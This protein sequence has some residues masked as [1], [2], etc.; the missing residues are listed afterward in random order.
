ML[1]S[2]F[3]RIVTSHTNP[4]GTRVSH[5]RNV[6]PSQILE[7]FPLWVCQEPF[8]K[9]E[10]TSTGPNGQGPH[11]HFSTYF[12]YTLSVPP[13]SCIIASLIVEHLGIHSPPGKEIYMGPLEKGGHF[14]YR[15]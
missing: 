1:I 11:I 4:S 9:M 15:W 6:G 10:V 13:S 2:G 8:P 3:I 7:K 14:S 5:D 12:S